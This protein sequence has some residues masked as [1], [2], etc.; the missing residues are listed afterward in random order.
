M[1]ATT[2]NQ[3]TE[4]DS[5]KL[6]KDAINYVLGRIR[7]DANIRYHMGGFTEAFNRL[8]I[9]HSALTG[10]S[11]EAI[12]RDVLCPK[13]SQKAYGEMIRDIKNIMD[14]A[15]TS[16]PAAACAAIAKLLAS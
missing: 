14:S 10:I 12:E 16:E 2:E 3:T 13:L 8:A 5:L 1:S 4:T 7:N 9:A 15:D 6:A 11:R